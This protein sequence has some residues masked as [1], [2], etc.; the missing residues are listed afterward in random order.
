[1]ECPS[2]LSVGAHVLVYHHKALKK[3]VVQAVEA[4][5]AR[6]RVQLDG[7]TNLIWIKDV[8]LMVPLLSHLQLFYV[9][10]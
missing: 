4:A 9:L 6:Y 2:V 3:G 5:G 1:L 7:H 10:N 8:D